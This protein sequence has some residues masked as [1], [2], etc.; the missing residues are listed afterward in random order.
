MEQIEVLVP[1]EQS[2][3]TVK[4]LE[5]IHQY[6]G[7]KNKLPDPFHLY[8]HKMDIASE[9]STVRFIV[10]SMGK[11]KIIMIGWYIENMSKDK[12]FKVKYMCKYMTKNLQE[13]ISTWN[14]SF[15]MTIAAV[16]NRTIGRIMGHNVNMLPEFIQ[17]DSDYKQLKAYL[18]LQPRSKYHKVLTKDEQKKVRSIISDDYISKLR[19]HVPQYNLIDQIKKDITMTSLYEDE[20]TEKLKE[21]MDRVLIDVISYLDKN[22]DYYEN[23]INMLSIYNWTPRVKEISMQFYDWIATTNPSDKGL[24]QCSCVIG[25]EPGCSILSWGEEIDLT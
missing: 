17:N 20:E 13:Y 23:S 3:S 1:R 4:E 19:A 15:D 9:S 16:K 22:I 8:L 21:L 24:G 14:K 7:V 10:M 18:T 5:D 11:K 2:I 25:N 12:R 6:I